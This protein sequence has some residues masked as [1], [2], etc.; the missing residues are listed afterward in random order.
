MGDNV[1]GKP[2]LASVRERL[3]EIEAQRTELRHEEQALQAQEKQLRRELLPL[4]VVDVRWVF[5]NNK[6]TGD[7]TYPVYASSAEAAREVV[8]HYLD[9]TLNSRTAGVMADETGSYPIEDWRVSVQ[10]MDSFLASALDQ[11]WNVGVT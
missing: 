11:H 2:T 8:R 5:T 1:T 6:Q 9:V 3:A 7:K 4:W 10:S